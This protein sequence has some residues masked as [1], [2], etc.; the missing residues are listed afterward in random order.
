MHLS[1]YM[2]CPCFCININI[3]DGLCRQ[4]K[5]PSNSPYAIIY[6]WRLQQ[7]QDMKVKN[8]GQGMTD[9]QVKT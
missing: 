8:G 7:E 9:A 2:V 3:D 4:I 6:Q 5:G 1:R